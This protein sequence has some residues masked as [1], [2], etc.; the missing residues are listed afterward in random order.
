CD[1]LLV[2]AAVRPPLAPAHGL[3]LPVPAPPPRASHVAGVPSRGRGATSRSPPAAA[4][5]SPPGRAARRPRR[6]PLSRV[7]S[8]RRSC[9][10]ALNVPESHADL[11]GAANVA[12]LTT[13]GKDGLPQST[14][15][16]FIVDDDGEL[17]SSITD[18][19]QKYK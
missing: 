18:V 2:R 16:W 6:P 11:L 13:V 7:R 9:P 4:R 10:M 15:V 5:C 19:R 17:K 12:T 3:D 1:G 8:I 14:A